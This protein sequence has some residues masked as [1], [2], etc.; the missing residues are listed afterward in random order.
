MKSIN[1]IQKYLHIIES[2]TCILQIFV[3]IFSFPINFLT[4]FGIYSTPKLLEYV[5]FLPLTY[6]AI[7]RAPIDSYSSR[8]IIY[9]PSFVSDK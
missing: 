2:Y 4:S 6:K 5:T 3:A 1:P 8:F 9:V 7:Q